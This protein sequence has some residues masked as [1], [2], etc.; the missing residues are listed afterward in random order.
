MPSLI[1]LSL[2]DKYQVAQLAKV[3]QLKEFQGGY[4]IHIWDLW[5]D[6]LAAR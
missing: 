3:Q 1:R 4:S 5:W 2:K 6:F